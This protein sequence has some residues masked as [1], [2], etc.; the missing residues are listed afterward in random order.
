[1][2]MFG[3]YGM[4]GGG[5]IFMVLFWVVIIAGGLYLIKSLTEKGS[6]SAQAESAE[7][8]L[9]KRYAKGEIRQEE[10]EKIKK[11]LQR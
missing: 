3:D 11:D 2:H 7:E 1:M 6:N 4:G 10:F 5:V 9:K 8:I